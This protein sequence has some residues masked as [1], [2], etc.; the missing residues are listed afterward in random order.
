MIKKKELN[1]IDI[2]TGLRVRKLRIALGISQ[3]MLGDAIEVT[4]QQIQ[5]YER[6]ANRMGSS[7]LFYICQALNITVS[8]LF[9]DIEKD[10]DKPILTKAEQPT[11]QDIETAKIFRSLT[12]ENKNAV[13]KIMRILIN[14]Q[15]IGK[16]HG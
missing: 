11:R 8:E 16:R 6:G 2:L 7:R 15:L 4:F 14:T 9:K 3:S 13:N 12:K 1:K 10:A 5:K